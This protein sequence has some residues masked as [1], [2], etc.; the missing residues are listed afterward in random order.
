[1]TQNDQIRNLIHSLS[2]LS[3][4]KLNSQSIESLGLYAASTDYEL[5]IYEEAYQELCLAV[6]GQPPALHAPPEPLFIRDFIESLPH[7]YNAA[8]YKICIELDYCES[9]K[10]VVDVVDIAG[11]IADVLANIF[12]IKTMGIPTATWIISKKILD[13]MCSCKK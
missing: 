12:D 8:H 1:M 10:K 4:D 9:T 7:I 6:T 5:K 3:D 2:L 13:K 11:P